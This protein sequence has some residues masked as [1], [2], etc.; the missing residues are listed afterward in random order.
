MKKWAVIDVFSDSHL[1]GLQPLS[2]A[3]LQVGSVMFVGGLIKKSVFADNL[4]PVVDR[5]YSHPEQ[6]DFTLSWLAT[7]AF[8][9]QIYLDF[10]GYS[11]MAL[12]LAWMLGI[13][14]P[15]NF[16]YPYIS[17]NFSE[18]WTRWHVTLSCWLRDYLYIPLGG[19]RCSLPRT[20]FNLMVTMLLGGLWHGAG[21]TFVFWG[22]LHGSYLVVYHALSRL[23]RAWGLVRDQ[24]LGRILSLLGW[25]LTFALTSFTWVFFRASSFDHA[26]T[27]SGAMLGLVHPVGAL[28]SVRMYEMVMILAT[29]G[30][31]LT[32]PLFLGWFQK[33][34]VDWWWV[35]VPIPVRGLAYAG[36]TLFVVVLGGHTQKFIYFD[37]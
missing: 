15:R 23:Y 35:K 9:M 4:A 22:F 24:G 14:L 16:L 5:L 36:V 18:F 1:E 21:W 11:E 17:R 3:N 19:S 25:P 7:T 33:K 26:W 37:F 29:F 32:E 13:K 34:G 8:G 2:R 28:S 20:Y 10:S 12:G 31:V 27:I 6:L 30:L